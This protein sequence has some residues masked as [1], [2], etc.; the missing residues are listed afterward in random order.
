[1]LKKLLLLLFIII[2]ALASNAQ[3]DYSILSITQFKAK[4][5]GITL[6]TKAINRAIEKTPENGTLII[7]AGKWLTGTIHLKSNMTLQ[8]EEGAELLGSL[9]PNDYDSYISQKD[10]SK[11]D[12]GAGTRNSNV[13]T[14][15]RW[16]KALILGE[17]LENTRICGKGTINGQHLE[18]SL[19]EESMRG[20]H[21]LLLAECKNIEVINISIIKASNYAILGYELESANF[22]NLSINEGW[23]G[24]HIRGGSNIIINNCDIKTGDDAIAGGYW[25][26]MYIANC[27]LNSSCN[28]IRVIE[29][30]EN[31][32]ITDC[33]IFGPGVY[34]HRTRLP[35]P[36]TY[37]LPAG[38]DMLW[39]IVIEPGAWGDAPGV[40]K[41]FRINKS[42]IENTW[43][44][45]AYS[46]GEN[47]ECEDLHLENITATHIRG[48]AQPINRQECVKSWSQIICNNVIVTK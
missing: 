12:T 3:K 36:I 9:N 21:T 38:H 46:M 6:C 11:Y 19:G 5:D 41:N 7:P 39:G 29:P 32:M 44:P 45:I 14:D 48:V 16:T 4:G 35:H 8:I 17:R 30:C 43:G 31:V 37:P 42:T 27:S 13:T 22:E 1:M 47:N 34:P 18:D 33:H 28:G 25:N 10:M 20:P 26:N 2:Y 24:I 23:D 15:S 40:T